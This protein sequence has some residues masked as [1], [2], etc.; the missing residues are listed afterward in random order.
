M[1]RDDVIRVN[2]TYDRSRRGGI[3]RAA[4]VLLVLIAVMLVIIAIPGWKAFRYDSERQ[5]CVQAMKSAR[6]GLIIEYLSRFKEG[7]VQEAMATLDEVMPERPNI[8]PSG[9]TVYLVRDENGI[10]QPICGLHDTDIRHRTRLNASRAM[11][12][13]KDGLRYARREGD[14]KLESIDISLN[15]KK[16]SIVR[17]FA[18]ESISRGTATTLG[19]EG[20]VAFFALAGSGEFETSRQARAGE[21]CYFVYAEP[22]SCA[23]WR[24]DDGWTGDAYM[25]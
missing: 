14:D 22:D 16:L 24:A 21:V 1:R 11:D 3:T 2:R 25:E 6:D 20:T 5:A 17:V 7:S 10:Y 9:G 19:Y 23:V 15:G 18:E 8:C 13:L 4:A 12:L